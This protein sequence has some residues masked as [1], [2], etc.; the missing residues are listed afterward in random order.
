MEKWIALGLAVIFLIAGVLHIFSPDLFLV[1][2][3]PYIPFHREVV[4]LTGYF[5]IFLSLGLFFKRTRKNSG[6]LSAMYFILIL[7]VHLHVSL[8]EIPMF[9]ISSPWVL[10]GRTLFQSVFIYGG[11]RVGRYSN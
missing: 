6:L 11:Y 10:W 2:M 1:A 3:P 5:E 7:P 8:N 4:Y 9:G